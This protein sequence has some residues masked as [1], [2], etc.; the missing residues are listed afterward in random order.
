MCGEVYIVGAKQQKE[1]GCREDLLMR[2]EFQGRVI[3]KGKW[4]PKGPTNTWRGPMLQ[5]DLTHEVGPALTLPQPQNLYHRWR[6]Y[7][8]GIYNCVVRAGHC[9]LQN[10]Y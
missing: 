8:S 5:P 7:C 2:R 4:R 3:S 9:W 6:C 1:N 10:I